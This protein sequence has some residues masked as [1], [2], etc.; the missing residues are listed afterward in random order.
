MILAID[1]GEVHCGVALFE[2][3]KCYAAYEMAPHELLAA[4]ERWL[5][6]GCVQAMVVE[7][8]RLYASKAATQVGSQIK[9]V[10][11]IGVLRWLWA[12][13][14][15]GV[16]WREQGASIKKPTQAILAAKKVR[17]TAKQE[18]AGGHAL[19]AELHGWHYLLNGKGE[20]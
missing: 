18:K 20:S 12:K 1:P 7:E 16:I 4:V 9:T 15:E 5:Q 6:E 19:D 2:K 13:H 14:G 10:E 8:F 3:R 11:V 17:S